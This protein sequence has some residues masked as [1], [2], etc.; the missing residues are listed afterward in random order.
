MCLL[1][2]VHHWIKRWSSGWLFFNQQ[3]VSFKVL[4]FLIQEISIFIQNYRSNRYSFFFLNIQIQ[5]QVFRSIKRKSLN[6]VGRRLVFLRL[7]LM[8]EM[9]VISVD[10]IHKP[11]PVVRIHKKFLA[12]LRSRRLVIIFISWSM[13][14]VATG[15]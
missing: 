11:S 8:T 14:Q 3:Y 13:T 1:A 2:L 5:Q 7:A 6:C 15:F 10:M 9:T 12:A 4:F